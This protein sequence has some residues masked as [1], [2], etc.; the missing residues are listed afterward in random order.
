M[1][2]ELG[3]WAPYLGVTGH[4]AVNVVVDLLEDEASV[5][6]SETPLQHKHK[7]CQRQKQNRL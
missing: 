3:E 2:E 7:P 4:E 1:D 6:Q 5:H